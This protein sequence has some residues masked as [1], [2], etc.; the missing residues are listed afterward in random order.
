MNDDTPSEPEDEYEIGYGKPPKQHRF[1]KNDGRP[2]GR[3]KKGVANVKTLIREEHA[4]MVR[5]TDK[6]GRVRMRPN[7]AALIRQ[8][9]QEA[10][11]KDRVRE[12][13]INRALEFDAEDEAH[14]A[15]KT[16][17]ALL[18]EDAIILRRYLAPAPDASAPA[19]GDDEHFERFDS[20]QYEG[21]DD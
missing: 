15:A 2:R 13:N 9:V 21:R 5:V 10:Y 17:G 16:Q 8:D 6:R 3:R 12:R 4:R 20:T 14:A 19:T 7:L 11:R 18:S 1:Q